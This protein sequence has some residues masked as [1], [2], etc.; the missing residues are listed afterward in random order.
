MLT[1]ILI[2]GNLFLSRGSEHPQ[3]NFHHF[4]EFRANHS[5]TVLSGHSSERNASFNIPSQYRHLSV[6]E[7]LN[8]CANE[9]FDEAEAADS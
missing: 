4:G 7:I 1:C 5:N 3:Y 6:P 9:A 8:V 2:A